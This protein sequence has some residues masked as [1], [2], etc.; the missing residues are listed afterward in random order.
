MFNM[1]EDTLIPLY[2]GL[3]VLATYVGINIIGYYRTKHRL[4]NLPNPS[5]AVEQRLE[6]KNNTRKFLESYLGK[7]WAKLY[8]FSEI[9]LDQGENLALRKFTPQKS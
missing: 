8:R 9:L 4:Q 3:P 5:K 6:A 2:M 7:S 1:V